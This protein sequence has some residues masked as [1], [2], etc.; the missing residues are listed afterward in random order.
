MAIVTITTTPR[1][2]AAAK[3]MADSYNADAGT[4]LTP[5]QFATQEIQALLDR[6]VDRTEADQRLSKAQAYQIATPEDQAAI[7]LILAKYV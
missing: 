4:T 2:D 7:D 1:Q 6:W 3:R 5:L